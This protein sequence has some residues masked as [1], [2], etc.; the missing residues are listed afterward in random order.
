MTR[1]AFAA[2]YRCQ[3]E[4]KSKDGQRKPMERTFYFLDSKPTESWCIHCETMAQFVRELSGRKGGDTTKA[5]AARHSR[6]ALG[7]DSSI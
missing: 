6:K 2:V 1:Q 7:V 4:S 3:C 5:R